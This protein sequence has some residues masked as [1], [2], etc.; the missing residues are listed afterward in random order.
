MTI[1][2]RCSHASISKSGRDSDWQ[3]IGDPTEGALLVG[4][5]KASLQ[6]ADGTAAVILHEIPFDS[7]RK[8]M[9]ATKATAAARPGGLGRVLPGDR[10]PAHR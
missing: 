10:V 3:V 8:M 9:S 4:A 2:T 5:G 7:D 1:G 6:H